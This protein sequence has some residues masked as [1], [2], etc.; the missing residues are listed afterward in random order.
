M[1][2]PCAQLLNELQARSLFASK[3]FVA[4]LPRLF[5]ETGMF[6]E[7]RFITRIVVQAHDQ[8]L[9]KEVHV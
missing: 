3:N 5:H 7:V 1:E 8:L 9:G 6:F 2:Q 4:D